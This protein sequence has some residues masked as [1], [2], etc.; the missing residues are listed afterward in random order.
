MLSPYQQAVLLDT[1]RPFASRVAV[2]GSE[3]R[4]EAR[5]GSDLDILVTLRDAADRPALGLRWF[6]LEADLAE[7]LGRP[8]D[9]VTD[10]A[11][12]RHVRPFVD[13]DLVVLHED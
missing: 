1:L 12:N 10:A 5:P 8:V 6:A 11:L 7:R 4:G 13:L 9:L 3:A 2:F